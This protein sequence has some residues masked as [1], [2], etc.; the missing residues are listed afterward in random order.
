M[1]KKLPLLLLFSGILLLLNSCYST[2]AVYQ[3]QPQIKVSAGLTYQ[4]FYDNLSPYGTWIDY[5]GYGHVWNPRIEAGF[6]PY[7]TNGNW[8]YSQQGWAW[9]SNYNWGWAPF[10]Y[11]SWLY[12]DGYGWLWVPGYQWSPAWVTWGTVDNYYAWAPLMPEVNIGVQFSNWRPHP[13]YWNVVGRDHVY[14]RNISNV[15][16]QNNQNTNITKN[17][18]IINNYNT[19]NLINTNNNT[20]NILNNYY[21][22]G[23]D[24]NEV[25]RFTHT[26]IEP[27]G[28]KEVNNIKQPSQNYRIME[29]YRPQILQPQNEEARH[30]NNN[31][32]N[33]MGVNNN[34]DNYTNKQQTRFNQN[35]PV[36]TVQKGKYPPNT[37]I[38]KPATVAPQ[39]FHD[40]INAPFNLQQQPAFQHPVPREFRRVDNSQ[41]NP[42][43]TNSTAP[44]M[45]R[46]QQRQNI[47]QLPIHRFQP[48]DIGRDKNG[49]RRERN[50]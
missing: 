40:N 8:R 21:S 4:S 14:D 35:L 11:G 12:D 3:P 20:K 19:T 1:I 24:V 44:V 26:K 23:P 28:F 48:N 29:V 16:I 34:E 30:A 47:E 2:N 7:A 37:T 18:T 45:Q 31:T 6:R 36:G 50:R 10:H 46:V 15:I 33:P 25:Q 27:V 39:Q 9:Q 43:N 13:Y 5:P 17:I 32:P 22:K 41:I 49:E 38:V 42:L